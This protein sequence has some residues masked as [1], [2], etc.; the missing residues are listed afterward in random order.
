VFVLFL[1][2]INKEQPPLISL[3]ATRCYVDVDTILR[4]I[5]A[6]YREEREDPR[7]SVFII[8]YKEYDIN[9]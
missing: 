5:H 9:Q 3:I 2:Y 4:I 6:K 1:S 8:D 7:F